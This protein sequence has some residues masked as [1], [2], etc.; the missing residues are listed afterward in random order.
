M[1]GMCQKIKIK[2]P[3]FLFFIFIFTINMILISLRTGLLNP[4]AVIEDIPSYPS[5]KFR[6]GL[7]KT[8]FFMDDQIL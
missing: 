2:K 1:I 3:S 6:I 4:F 8:K 7:G 5:L